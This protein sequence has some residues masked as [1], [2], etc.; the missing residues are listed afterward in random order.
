MTDKFSF[1]NQLFDCEN[2]YYPS[3]DSYFL[4]EQTFSSKSLIKNWLH[5]KN[6]TAIDLGC[7]SGI[8]SL[9]LLFKGS[10]KVT[11]IEL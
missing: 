7:G 5:E 4:A 6:A 1:N 11:A 3:E 10:S 9:N 2:V 8:Q